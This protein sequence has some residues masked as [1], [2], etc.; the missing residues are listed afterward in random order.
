M[1]RLLKNKYSFN[2]FIYFIQFYFTYKINTTIY[3]GLF[4]IYLS[5][6]IMKL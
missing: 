6:K 5:I 2:N 1:V 4:F 3:I